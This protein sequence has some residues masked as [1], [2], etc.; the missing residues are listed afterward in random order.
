MTLKSPVGELCDKFIKA[1]EV[2]APSL[3]DQAV[4]IQ[5]VGDYFDC[6]RRMF[7]RCA[8][9][10]AAA[11]DTQ[12]VVLAQLFIRLANCPRAAEIFKQITSLPL[13]ETNQKG[14]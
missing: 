7:H 10:A 8:R 12:Q 5:L 11:F 3:T 9:A 2:E 4:L 1:I 6:E 14:V 13:T